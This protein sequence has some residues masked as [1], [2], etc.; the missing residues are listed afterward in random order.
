MAEDQVEMF[1]VEESG[2]LLDG[3]MA[4][5]HPSQ[6]RRIELLGLLSSDGQHLG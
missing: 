6:Q 3:R 2:N 4:K 5:V 1:W